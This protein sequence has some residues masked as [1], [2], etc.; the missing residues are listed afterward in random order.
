[1]LIYAFGYRWAPALWELL[2]KAGRGSSC[3]RYGWI[4]AR[5]ARSSGR[6]MH[7][8]EVAF[9][10]W[11]KLSNN[12]FQFDFSILDYWLSSSH[13]TKRIGWSSS[14][15]PKDSL[16]LFSQWINAWSWPS[17]S[18]TVHLSAKHRSALLRSSDVVM[19]FTLPRSAIYG[20]LASLFWWST[21]LIAATC[22]LQTGLYP[23]RTKVWYINHYRWHITSHEASSPIKY[24]CIIIP[25]Y[26]RIVSRPLAVVCYLR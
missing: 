22:C 14:C 24:S 16:Y 25:I 9:L 23:W 19:R 13:F 12:L 8:F 20:F 21:S 1:M 4:L 18:S 26:F 15:S 5:K 17:R 6:A 11:F 2:R 10:Q 3:I 7:V